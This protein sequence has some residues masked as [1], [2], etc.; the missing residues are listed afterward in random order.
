[1]SKYLLIIIL[2]IMLGPEV[3]ATE[4]LV[5]GES[6]RNTA[7]TTA[8][9]VI[10]NTSQDISKVT[11]KWINFTGSSP[12]ATFDASHSESGVLGLFI[13]SCILF[14]SKHVNLLHLEEYHG[15]VSI[16]DSEII[17]YKS[18]ISSVC[19]SIATVS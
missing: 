8:P 10:F 15:S 16:R 14:G 6:H 1:M 2:Q 19:W 9:Y 17:G 18:V 4:I 7:I 13:E 11:F 5:R 12:R 3:T